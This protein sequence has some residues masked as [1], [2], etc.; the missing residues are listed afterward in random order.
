MEEAGIVPYI[1]PSL[2][3]K[4]RKIL[5]YRAKALLEEQ[6]TVIE[7]DTLFTIA[8]DLLNRPES[9]RRDWWIV[10][11]VLG[12]TAEARKVLLEFLKDVSSCPEPVL[13]FCQALV[14]RLQTEKTHLEAA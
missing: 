12:D 1:P 4:F 6:V 7:I 14:Q 3:T 10:Q 2:V 8:C 13:Y 11:Q 9:N 5:L